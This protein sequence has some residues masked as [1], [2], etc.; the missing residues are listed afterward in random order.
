MSPSSSEAVRPT[1][2]FLC[3]MRRELWENRSLYLAPLIIALVLAIGFCFSAVGLAQRRNALLLGDVTLQR[4]KIEMPYDVTTM[5]LL[6]SA[7]IIGVFYCLDALYGERRDRTILFWKSLP[8]SDRIAVLAK[9]S[10]PLLVLPAVI[11]G[12]ILALHLFMLLITAG[13]LLAHGMSPGST[14]THVPF[15][16]NWLALFYGLIAMSLWHAPVY[17]W[18]LAVSGWARRA[19]FLCAALP[20]FAV[21]LFERITFGTTHF[22]S[23]LKDR[24]MGF[25]PAAFEISSATKPTVGSFTQIAPVKFL[26]APGLWLGV[27]VALVFLSVA[28]RL[29]RSSAPL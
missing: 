17:G 24:L 20:P 19:T 22:S 1:Q 23:L 21:V 28:I 11:F 3:S 6:F 4:M 29:R 18:A 16:R 8:V 15:L 14:W 10:M 5:I 27:V 25:I 12:V 26:G 2:P 7:F 9:A 13:V